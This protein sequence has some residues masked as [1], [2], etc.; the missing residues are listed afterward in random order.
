MLTMNIFLFVC[1]THTAVLFVCN[2]S[3]DGLGVFNA[4]NR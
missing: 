3:V 2:I 1:V 4:V